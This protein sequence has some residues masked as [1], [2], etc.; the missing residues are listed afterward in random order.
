MNDNPQMCLGR[1][2]ILRVE[3]PTF[4]L[5]QRSNQRAV[6]NPPPAKGCCVSPILHLKIV[7]VVCM[8][9]LLI[10]AFW[11]PRRQGVRTRWGRQCLAVPHRMTRM[12]PSDASYKRWGHTPAA[13]LANVVVLQRPHEDLEH[14]N[15]HM[16]LWYLIHSGSFRYFPKIKRR[17]GSERLIHL[18]VQ[19]VQA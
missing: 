4:C 1:L 3:M 8:I 2:P 18:K 5:F 10:S 16:F 15:W 7:I 19:D 11:K 17:L 9:A 13:R 6:D 12:T 14:F